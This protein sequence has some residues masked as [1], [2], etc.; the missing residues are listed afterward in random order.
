MPRR[1]DPE[2]IRQAHAAGDAAR[3]ARNVAGD[4][5]L[6]RLPPTSNRGQRQALLETMTPAMREAVEAWE[7][8]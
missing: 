8:R 2:R 4:E 6:R 7:G 1:P 5:W 3:S